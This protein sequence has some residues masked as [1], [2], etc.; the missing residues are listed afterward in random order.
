MLYII[1]ILQLVLA[2]SLSSLSSFWCICQN[3]I[4]LSF[5][6]ALF[7]EPLISTDH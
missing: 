6:E 1:S 2:V 7:F 3:I 5:P 4:Y